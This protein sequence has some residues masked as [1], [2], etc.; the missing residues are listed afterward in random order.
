MRSDAKVPCSAS[1]N[2][3]MHNFNCQRSQMGQCDQ[4]PWLLNRIMI[5]L[6]STRYSCNKQSEAYIQPLLMILNFLSIEHSSLP[7][8]F[9]TI[10]ATTK[11][12]IPIPAKHIKKLMHDPSRQHIRSDNGPASFF[13]FFAEFQ[14]RFNFRFCTLL[15][16]RKSS[17]IE[18]KAYQQGH[19]NFLLEAL[20]IT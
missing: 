1:S 20:Q 9:V 15:K 3:Q 2:I 6:T 16:K 12:I 5:Q 4:I 8:H 7:K 11:A 10:I 13:L 14:F 18:W 19:S 17:G